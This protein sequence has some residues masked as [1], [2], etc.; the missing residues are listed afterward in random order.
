MS[1]LT[2][3]APCSSGSAAGGHGS[4][5]LL[6]VQSLEIADVK[7]VRP[8]KFG[9]D[10]GFFSETWNAKAFEDAGLEFDFVQDNHS[11]SAPA[12]VLRGLHFQKP[13]FAQGK[14]VRCTRGAILDI[15]VDIR[16]GSPTFGHYVSAKVSAE[17]WT[18]ILVPV[19]FAHGFVTLV[20]D[21]EVVYKVTALYSRE[22]DA[23]ITWNDPDIAIDWGL[24]EQQPILSDKDRA[25]PLLSQIETG[26]E[27]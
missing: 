5:T 10:R 14:L 20:P 1:V 18:Q 16:K 3:P 22:H 11:Y 15:A 24:D 8:R 4:L 27:F 9:D 19:G 13:P 23:N 25:A 26:F 6:D 12:N 7:L 21:T 2:L 17:N